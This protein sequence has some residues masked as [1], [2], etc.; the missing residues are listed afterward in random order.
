MD[1]EPDPGP[2]GYFSPMPRSHRL[3]ALALVVA[4]AACHKEKP[5]PVD[6]GMVLPNLPLPPDAQALTREG[7]T[8]AMQFLFVSPASPDSVVAYYRTALSSGVFRL[9]N[10]RTSGK[11]TEFYAE[12]DGP[13]IWVTV[14]PNG[15]DGSQVTIAG[16]TD[17]ASKAAMKVRAPLNDS[18]T[19]PARLPLKKP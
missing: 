9:I 16:A 12:Q 17:S 1:L 19:P 2:V 8:E 11:T 14:S 3:L 18:A 10:E 7:G 13:S 4:V 6:L 5:Q 15:N